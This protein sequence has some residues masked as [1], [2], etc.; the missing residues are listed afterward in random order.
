MQTFASDIDLLHWEPRLF[1]DTNASAVAQLLLSGSGTLA[2]T[3]FTIDSGSLIDSNVT[4]DYVIALSGSV[5]GSFPIVAVNSA[6][7]LT[8]SVLYDD[9]DA[10]D[11]SGSACQSESGSGINFAIR[12]LL[13]AA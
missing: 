8:L 9:L 11:G 13:T 1:C 4:S 12:H 10:D 7:Q 3:T 6:T 2:G 5:A